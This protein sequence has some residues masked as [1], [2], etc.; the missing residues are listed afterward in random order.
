[1]TPDEKKTFKKICKRLGRNK[2]RIC[3]FDAG[4]LCAAGECNWSSGIK[5]PNKF[6]SRCWEKVLWRIRTD[7]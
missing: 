2:K 4:L 1:M 6:I 5:R 3:P 7:R